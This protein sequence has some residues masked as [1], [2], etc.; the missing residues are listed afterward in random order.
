MKKIIFV[1]SAVFTV[2]GA[3]AFAA[4]LGNFRAFVMSEVTSCLPG[5]RASSVQPVSTNSAKQASVESEETDFCNLP[6]AEQRKIQASLSKKFTPLVMEKK[7]IA[8]GYAYKFSSEKTNLSELEQFINNESECCPYMS[9]KIDSQS[10]DKE[11]WVEVTNPKGEEKEYFETF[12][13][14]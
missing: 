2:F 8:N 4:N 7:A 1:M 6:S 12:L 5:V 14:K 11:I 9:F 13:T 10:N 3:V